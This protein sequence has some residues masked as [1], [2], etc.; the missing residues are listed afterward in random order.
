MDLI[1]R[2]REPKKQWVVEAGE[3]KVVPRPPNTL[4][5]Q[6]A[7]TLETLIQKIQGLERAL[8]TQNKHGQ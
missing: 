6:A 2:L 7:N 1:K 4:E 5:L 8:E 3:E